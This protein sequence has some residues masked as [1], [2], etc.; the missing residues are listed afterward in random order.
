MAG[1]AK[2]I[3]LVGY[4][5]YWVTQQHTWASE[6]HDLSYL[7]FARRL[8]AVN[9]A[10]GAGWFV[11]AVRAFLEP[12][13]CVVEKLAAFVAQRLFGSLMVCR[14]VDADH[15]R[16]GPPFTSQVLLHQI[17]DFFPRLERRCIRW[18]NCWR[19]RSRRSRRI[20]PSMSLPYLLSNS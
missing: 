4:C 18:C 2:S 20:A 6:T 7:L 17:P 5:E 10:V 11:I 13:V 9:G 3:E 19:L 12:Q 14:A 16:H 15:L 1:F 8:V